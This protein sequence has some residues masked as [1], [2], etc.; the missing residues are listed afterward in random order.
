MGTEQSEPGQAPRQ[1]AQWAMRA[2]ALAHE[3]TAA[4]C[5]L[6]ATALRSEDTT[7]AQERSHTLAIAELLSQRDAARHELEVLA[8]RHGQSERQLS[9]LTSTGSGRFELSAAGLPAAVPPLP[10]A[11]R[12]GC[13]KQFNS[14][15][16]E[17]GHLQHC[18]KRRQQRAPVL[19]QG[20][21]GEP[22]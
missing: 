11:C 2:A 16:G 1:V 3:V 22:A 18:P 15:L 10:V 14:V 20:Q 19:P 21:D 17:I 4:G 7:A 8:Q 13:G 5:I 9:P 12:E 6:S